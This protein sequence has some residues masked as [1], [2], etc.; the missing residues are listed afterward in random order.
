MLL[1]NTERKE[2]NL[3]E[4]RRG[5]L[6]Y[7]KHR[8]WTEGHTGIVTEASRTMLCVQYLPDIQNVLNHFFIPEEEAES[9][10]WEIR[11]SSDGLQNI[12]SFP[13]QPAEP[14]GPKEEKGKPEGPKENEENP[15]ESKENSGE[16]EGLGGTQHES[17]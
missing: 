9:G 7:A 17:E 1:V 4:I 11:Y 16:I 8:S 12:V 15:E 3:D 6:I 10:E 2:Y 14:E 5:T 13:E